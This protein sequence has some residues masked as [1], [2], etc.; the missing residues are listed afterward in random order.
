MKAVASKSIWKDSGAPRFP[1]LDRAMQTDVVVVG[2]GITGITAAYL[3]KKRA[4]KPFCSSAIDVF[5][6]TPAARRRHLTQVT[7][8]RLPKLVR[9]FGR[10]HARAVWDAGQA[11]IDRIESLIQ[12]EEINC[13]FQRVPGYLYA[14]DDDEHP[15]ELRK[16]ARLAQ[17]LGFDADFLDTVGFVERPGV[18]VPNQARIDPLLYLSGL[19]DRLSGRTS[20]VFEHSEAAE[21]HEDPLGVTVNGR[22]IRCQ[23]LIIAT[24]VPLM[25][26]TGL[27][28]ATLFQSKLA[29]FRVM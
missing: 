28:S 16:D 3:A 24:H 17:E 5:A 29:S 25:G 12:D 18:L 6:A 13:H 14:A 21:F 11:S 4:L 8:M 20:H 27:A 9:R 22:T 2:A 1:Q 10:D 7:D 19:L 15:D 23:H 26:N